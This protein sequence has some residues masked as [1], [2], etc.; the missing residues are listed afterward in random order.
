MIDYGLLI[1]MI[2]AF[3]VPELARHRWPLHSY[4]ED[5][6]FLDVALGPAAAGLIVGRITALGLDDP[7]SIGS[8]SDM[9]I[10]RSGVEF[11][12][13]VATAVAILAFGSRRAGLEPLTRVADVA[14]LAMLG[15]A[16][17]EASCVFRDGCF[18]PQSPVGLRPDG[19]TTT[20]APIGWFVALAVVV[21]AVGIRHLARRPAVPAW[22]V[23]TLAVTVVAAARSI[24]SIW[25]PHVGDGLTRQ[26]QTSIAIAVAATL[27]FCAG[28]A[29]PRY[30]SQST[31]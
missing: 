3:A 16:A 4:P 31:Q 13:G 11:W 20:M 29:F 9:A 23:A 5:A 18:G 8:L 19:L 1:S 6:R 21:G 30:E 2:L 28:L 14:P 15:Y 17:Y 12:P 10:I 27:V 7:N 22:T 26:H 25:L 24:G